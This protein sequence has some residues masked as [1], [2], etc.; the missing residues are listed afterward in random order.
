MI[1][2]LVSQ[3]PEIYQPIYGYPAL[4]SKV[5]RPCFD[6]LEKISDI[7]IA[8]RSL[9]GRQV[10]VL[11]LGCAQGF[12]SLKL[13][14]WGAIVHGID[15]LDKNIEVCQALAQENPELSA[16]F[17][18]GRIE[19]VIDRIESDQYDM[20][21]GLS[22][23]HHIV[24]EKG[25]SFVK[26]MIDK[27][28]VH[29]GVLVV[30]LA[31]REEPLYWA[32][33]QPEN[34]RWLLESVAFVHEIARHETHLAAIPRPLFVASN[35]FWLLMDSAEEFSKWSEDP[36]H[37]AVGAHKKSRRYFWG[38]RYILKQLQFNHEFGERNKAEYLKEIRIKELLPNVSKLVKYGCSE[39]EGWL[40]SEK[41]PGRLLLD[42]I[43]DGAKFDNR[44]VI[45]G[46]LS[47]LASLER[48]GFYH[49]D[50]RTWNV[51]V[52]KNGFAHLIDCGSISEK[53]E[54]CVWP[55]NIFFAFIIFVYEVSK[56]I[57]EH[58]DPLRSMAISPYGLPEPYKTWIKSFWNRP[59][60][61]WSFGKMH[62]SLNKM[63]LHG[64]RE[65]PLETA[66][67]LWARAIEEAIEKQKVF[68][69]YIRDKN[70][71]EIDDL[72]LMTSRAMQAHSVEIN[73]LK[74]S[75]EKLEQ[76]LSRHIEEVAIA[77]KQLEFSNANY[78][79]A[80]NKISELE[81][82]LARERE[83]SFQN[84]N[85][86]S[87]GAEV[88]ICHTSSEKDVYE[89][90]KKIHELTQN[91]HHW[92]LRA[93]ELEKERNALL[94]S[95]S[96]KLTSPLRKVAKFLI[97]PGSSLRSSINYLLFHSIEILSKP[98]AYAMP[99]ILR[100]PWVVNRVNK[101]LFKYP[102]L[103][104]QLVDV[105]RRGG[106][107]PGAGT[108]SPPKVMAIASANGDDE[109]MSSRAHGIYLELKA[110]VEKKKRGK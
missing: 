15:Y 62:D 54:D 10:R 78:F 7:Y 72:N 20:V 8:L 75:F 13:A 27:A 6:R 90:E 85:Q 95:W 30:E 79:R 97:A 89:R 63:P 76:S 1:E 74:T 39:D 68:A 42:L 107:L 58:P 92:W 101:W 104:R 59:M 103:Y 52:E 53:P 35:R 55:R 87:H 40:I 67:E 106:V 19:E 16:T 81:H 66:E 77:E 61:E 44:S 9:L 24:Q 18:Q 108:Y 99:F 86:V 32:A 80:E 29:V 57:V 60:A 83:I 48:D 34:P 98:I 25:Q 69:S 46:V 93:C 37:L 102:P 70:R 21:L 71:K 100:R 47:Q 43:R 65:A 28:A 5:S 31:L 3:L 96:W 49:D 23:F 33:A 41:I 105:A 50:V 64:Y 88:A 12:F 94:N 45:L 14:E 4:S 2:S 17:E 56:G 11:D 84:T 73:L 36:H 26:N 51:I 110:A 109:N 38:Q 22:V 82:Q 91:S